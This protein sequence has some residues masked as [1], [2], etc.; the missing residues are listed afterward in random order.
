MAPAVNR[1]GWVPMHLHWQ[2][3]EA[4]VDWCWLG[5]RRFTEPFFDDTIDIALQTL[6]N[7][8]F[9][10]RTPIAE[11]G[12]WHAA[13]PGMTP[14]GF[15]FH[16][17]RCGSTLISQML[18]ALPETVVISEASPIDRL[19]RTTRV[20]EPVRADWL[21]WM[22]GALGQKRAETQ[23]RYFIKFDSPTAM[24][25]PFIRRVFPSVPWVFVYRNPE[26]VLLSQM[27]E[28]AAAMT[29]GIVTDLYVTDSPLTPEEYAARVIGRLCESAAHAM[30][31]TDHNGML[32]NYSQLP[33][34]VWTDIARHFRLDLQPGDL[35]RMQQATLRNAKQPGITFQKSRHEVPDPVRAAAAQWILPYYNELERIRQTSV[36]A[37]R[38]P[39]S[40]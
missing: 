12:D 25:L 31:I 32:V 36:A 16:M 21:R 22:I 4:F 37:P 6:F 30:K 23:S 17:S 26:D 39:Q 7:R 29:P 1:N 28:T 35:A 38:L 27:R 15:I 2:G 5:T 40:S 20:P 14:S 34:I 24:A 19:A 10:H 8:L 33:E 18:A 9:M 11:L 13:S 3:A